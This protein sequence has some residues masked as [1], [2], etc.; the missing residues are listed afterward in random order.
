[1]PF[2]KT[3]NHPKEYWTAH[4][5]K[6]LL[7]HISKKFPELDVRRSEPVR[8]DI[9]DQIIHDLTQSRIVIADLTDVNPNVLWELGVR[10]SFSN[11]T[12]TIAEEGMDLPFDLARKGT[13]FYDIS[14]HSYSSEIEQFLS[15]LNKAIQDCLDNPNRPDS[16]VLDAIRRGTFFEM[17]TRE[18]I[19]RKLNAII[20]ELDD[21]LQSLHSISATID[22]NIELRTKIAKS[23]DENLISQLKFTT[24]RL[25]I[26]AVE[27]LVV[28]QYLTQNELFYKKCS[29]LLNH[30]FEVNQQL[31]IWE[32]RPESTEKWIKSNIQSAI[33]DNENLKK[34]FE[35]QQQILKESR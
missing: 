26:S 30:M 29:D 34:E 23:N 16:P 20:F 15:R 13:L 21:N 14:H 5:E 28:N 2:S 27:G 3:A 25:R 12:I 17:I 1:M 35:K 9:V 4:F 31:N 10:Q 7:P 19:I 8:G 24:A 6:F 11:R 22:S 32:M 33:R 18:E